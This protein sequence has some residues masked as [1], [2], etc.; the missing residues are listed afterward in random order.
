[1]MKKIFVRNLILWFACLSACTILISCGT[2]VSQEKTENPVVL[3]ESNVH[4][5]KPTEEPVPMKVALIVTGE[6][7]SV[8]ETVRS[9]AKADFTELVTSD[10]TGSERFDLVFIDLQEDLS[11]EDIEMLVYSG[12]PVVVYNRVGQSLPDDFIEVRFGVGFPETFQQTI[13]NAL[14]YPPHDTPVRLAG[15]FKTNVT[16]GA[17]LF[18]QYFSEGKILIKEAYYGEDGDSYLKWIDKVFDSFYPGMLDA[19]CIEDPELA[20]TFAKE[21]IRAERDDFEIFTTGPNPELAKLA[22]SHPSILPM[23]PFFDEK[24]AE[25][26]LIDMFG[27]LEE[28]TLPEEDIILEQ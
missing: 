20:L 25:E 24:M 22:F 9:A 8:I 1:M 19:V 14:V 18:E 10:L 23:E 16:P 7:P 4:S 5:P 13:E 21:M 26:A 3:T 15:V 28:S 12:C 17:Y 11:E 27:R 6:D 2:I